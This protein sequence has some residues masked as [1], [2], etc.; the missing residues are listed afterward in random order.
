MVQEFD[1]SILAELTKTNVGV[2]QLNQSKLAYILVDLLRSI[3]PDIQKNCLQVQLYV[4][5]KIFFYW[6]KKLLLLTSITFCS[7]YSNQQ[8]KHCSL[9]QTVFNLL[10]D[11][12]R[13]AQIEMTLGLN[14]GLLLNLCLSEYPAIQHLTLEVLIMELRKMGPR[15]NEILQEFLDAN[16]VTTIM[17]IIMVN[18]LGANHL[19]C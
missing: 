9:F 7:I 15:K 4:Y 2:C 19:D 17:K 5:R 16:G 18:R 13:D 3:D 6:E 12:V 10:K 1:T 11:P 8:R 14:I